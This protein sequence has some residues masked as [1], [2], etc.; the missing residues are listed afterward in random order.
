MILVE[1]RLGSRTP[2]VAVGGARRSVSDVCPMC[3]ALATMTTSR[4]P[5]KRRLTIYTADEVV[6]GLEDLARHDERPVSVLATS[7]NGTL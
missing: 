4:E 6:N 2:A 3:G 1:L 7:K 5:R